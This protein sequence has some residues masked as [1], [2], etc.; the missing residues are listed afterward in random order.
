[1]IHNVFDQWKLGRSKTKVAEKNLFWSKLCGWTLFLT[2]VVLHGAAE[3][4][5]TCRAELDSILRLWENNLAA[6]TLGPI[7]PCS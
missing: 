1:M 6:I 2:P 4:A 7:H 3:G 5:C